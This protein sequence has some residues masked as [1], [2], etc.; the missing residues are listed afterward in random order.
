[1]NHR[2]LLIV[3]L[4]AAALAG[5]GL[6]G[7][8]YPL[9]HWIHDS[10]IRDLGVFR[11][12][13]HGLDTLFGMELWYWLASTVAVVLG[14]LALIPTFRVPRRVASALIVAGLVQFATLHTMILMKGHFGRLRPHQLFESGVWDPIWHA[15]G[16]S[17]PS[18]HSAFYFG[19]FLPLAA[20]ATRGWQRALLLAVPLFAVLGRLDMLRHFLSDVATSAM[21]A[22]LYSLLAAAILHASSAR[23]KAPVTATV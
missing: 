19:L 11:H 13:L 12:G 6:V 2:L 16:G 5:V 7:L 23:L 4:L 14:L 18:G 20:F 21:I 8:D 10:S 17:F 9:A 22:A 1:M 15:G 3:A